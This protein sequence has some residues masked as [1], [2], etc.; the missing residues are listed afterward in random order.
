VGSAAARTHTRALSYAFPRA[1][2]PPPLLPATRRAPRAA[3]AMAAP[4]PP[5]PRL[6]LEF[7]PALL[8]PRAQAQGACCAADSLR[9]AHAAAVRHLCA[10][11]QTTHAR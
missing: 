9:A 4:S 5:P 8:S 1:A 2:S 11:V 10:R 6:R 7:D 3:A